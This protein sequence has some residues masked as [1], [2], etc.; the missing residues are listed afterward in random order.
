MK[1]KGLLY[2]FL[3]KNRHKKNNKKNPFQFIFILYTAFEQTQSK[4]K[5]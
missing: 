3:E 1:S 2:L 5:K 4:E